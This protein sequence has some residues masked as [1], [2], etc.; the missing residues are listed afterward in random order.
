MTQI[1]N[2][3]VTH[4]DIPIRIDKCAH[5]IIDDFHHDTT[6]TENDVIAAYQNKNKPKCRGCNRLEKNHIAIRAHQRHCYWVKYIDNAQPRDSSSDIS[7]DSADE[8]NKINYQW[9]VR[10]IIDVRGGGNYP[11]FW[12][13]WW[14]NTTKQGNTRS[15]RV[16]AVMDNFAWYLGQG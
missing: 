16:A 4:G 8:G 10:K 1:I 15:A 13:I 6:I 7:D 14:Q 9:T 12:L 11:R 2:H 3:G 5:I